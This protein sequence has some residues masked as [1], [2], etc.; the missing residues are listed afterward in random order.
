[1]ATQL[2]SG[3]Q[4]NAAL[5]YYNSTAPLGRDRAKTFQGK[6]F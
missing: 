1:M 6:T 3:E 5:E 4:H 2:N